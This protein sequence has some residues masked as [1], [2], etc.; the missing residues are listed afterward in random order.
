M[1]EIKARHAKE[2][3]DLASQITSLKKQALKKTRRLVNQKCADLEREMD[4]RHRRELGDD[5]EPK[6]EEVDMAAL[7]LAQMELKQAEQSGPASPDSPASSNPTLPTQQV[8]LSEDAT[9]TTT[10][11]AKPKRNRQKERLA[12]RQAEIDRIKAEAAAEAEGSVDYRGI[13]AEAMASLCQRQGLQIHEINPDGHC[14]FALI[15]DQL[16]QRLDRHVSIDQLRQEAGDFIKSHPDDFVPFLFDET[17]GEMRELDDYV[18]QLQT[19][20]MWGSDMEILA[21]ARVYQVAIEVHQAGA[22]T[23]TYG[24][25]TEALPLKIAYFK[26]LYG[27][28]EH[29]NSLRDR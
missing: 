5:D 13:E 9:N 18:K 2:R 26:H 25:S 17:T 24:E 6:E 29:Y 16:D 12:R 3:R 28:G 22:D 21:L 15:A 1:D 14:L 7:L 4:E 11:T 10:T 19:T 8:S 20:P 23:I 27:L